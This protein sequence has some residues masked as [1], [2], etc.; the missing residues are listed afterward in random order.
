MITEEEQIQRGQRLEA[1]AKD[2]AIKDA[3]GTLEKQYHVE[4]KRAKSEEERRIAQSK[5]LVLDDFTN[6]LRGTVDN[7][8]LLRA[9]NVKRDRR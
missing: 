8:T 5:A 3:I 2:E 4:F 1:Y 7:Y 9:N 6:Q